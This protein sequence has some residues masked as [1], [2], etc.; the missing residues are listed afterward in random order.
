MISTSNAY[1]VMGIF[2]NVTLKIYNSHNVLRKEWTTHNNVTTE[3]ITNLLDCMCLNRSPV[4][5]GIRIMHTDT[6]GINDTTE[7]TEFTSRRVIQG[8]VPYLELKFYLPSDQLNGYTL[9]GAQLLTQ[10]GASNTIVF[11]E[12]DTSSV[13]SP[14]MTE[15]VLS[16]AIAKTSDKSV[17]YIWRIGI[18]SEFLKSIS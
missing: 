6:S 16:G 11:A 13:F 7:F 2:G 8:N 14:G 17:I 9:T 10:D 15:K 5:T 1:D 4:I 12:V 3:G 18:T